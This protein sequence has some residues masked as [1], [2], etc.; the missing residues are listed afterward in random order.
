MGNT[1][2]DGLSTGNRTRTVRFAKNLE[3]NAVKRNAGNGLVEE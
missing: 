1:A 2:V 3:I